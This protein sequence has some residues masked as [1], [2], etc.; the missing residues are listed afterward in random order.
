VAWGIFYNAGQTC[1]AGSRVIVPVSSQDELVARSAG[2]RREIFRPGD[3]LDP[4]TVFRSLVDETQLARC[5]GTSRPAGPRAPTWSSVAGGRCGQR[6]S[7]VEPTIVDNVTNGMT[8]ARAE[9]FGPVLA[10]IPYSGDA[11]E[12]VRLANDTDFGSRRPCGPVMSRRPTGP[13][14]SCARARCG[15]TRSTRVT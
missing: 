14:D 8:L 1:N 7:Y 12:G 3:P 6:R 13:R 2:S 4:D 5:S 9:I 10:V 11:E 15:S